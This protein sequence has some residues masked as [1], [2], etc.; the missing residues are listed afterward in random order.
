MFLNNRGLACNIGLMRRILRIAV[1]AIVVLSLSSLTPVISLYLKKG[2]PQ[3]TNSEIAHK[4]KDNKGDAFEFI[5]FGDNHA[6]FIFTDSAAVKLIRN[7]NREDRFKKL[8]IDFV[9]SVGDV[10]FSKGAESDYITYNKLRSEIKWPVVSAMGN[11]DY[12]N[13]GWRRFKKYI[14][15]SEFSFTDRSSYF[16]FMDNTISDISEEQFLWLE[17]ELNKASAYRHKFILMH[18][19]PL[20]LYQ[21]SWFR[22][23][24]SPW[25]YKAMKLCQKHG[26]DIVFTGHE[27]MF[28]ESVFG[29]VR[30]VTTGGG[31][32]FTQIPDSDGGFLHYVVVR[33]YG[34]Y[35]DYEV[36]KVFPPFWEFVTY[37]MWK[38]AFYGL[39][40]VFFKDGLLF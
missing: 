22:P 8:P 21:Q 3:L 29:G 4:L 16:I 24:L 18:K 19:S 9:A 34:D 5:V 17:E 1:I 25:S 15:N 36:R 38:E 32:M 14:G 31:G 40:S 7:M 26:V 13:G 2:T 37:Y 6:G 23:E 12:Q 28:R 35:V 27:H 39:K 10:T 33:V 30:Y 20:S 11:H